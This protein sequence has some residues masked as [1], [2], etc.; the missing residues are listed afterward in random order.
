MAKRMRRQIVSSKRRV[1]QAA[2]RLAGEWLR[3]QEAVSLGMSQV[4]LIGKAE[5]G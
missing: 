2:I 4:T 5:R 3:V 1:T